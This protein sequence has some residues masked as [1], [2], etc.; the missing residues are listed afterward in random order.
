[1]GKVKQ[2]LLERP[3]K[4]ERESMYSLARR[5]IVSVNEDL[6]ISGL[7]EEH[8]RDLVRLKTALQEIIEYENTDSRV[9][10]S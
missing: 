8:E 5:M 6:K 7:E 9:Q 2:A 10:Q 4:S 3:F 1:M